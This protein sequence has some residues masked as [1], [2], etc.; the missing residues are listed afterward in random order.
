MGSYIVYADN[1]HDDTEAVQA[2]Y[3]GKDVYYSDGTKFQ[4]IT[5]G[6]KIKG[7]IKISKTIRIGRPHE[8]S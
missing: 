4:G 5:D 2:Y 6:S 7:R 1:I 8:A 3:D